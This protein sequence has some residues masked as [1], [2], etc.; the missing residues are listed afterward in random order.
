MFFEYPSRPSIYQHGYKYNME[1]I[2]FYFIGLMSF[3]FHAFARRMLTS[4]SIDEMFLPRYVKICELV[5]YWLFRVEIAF[6]PFFCV[7]FYV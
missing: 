5:Y 1:K 7:L 2:L 3:L 6:L 4:F